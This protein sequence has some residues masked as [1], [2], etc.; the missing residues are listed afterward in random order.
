MRIELNQ[1][2]TSRTA[3]IISKTLPSIDFNLEAPTYRS[4]TK[5]IFKPSIH[6]QISIIVLKKC[7]YL[8][9]YLWRLISDSWARGAFLA[10]W[11]RGITVLA[12]KKDSNVDPSNF[13][14]CYLFCQKSFYLYTS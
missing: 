14:L 9:T 3:T 2:L 12:Y 7:P 4:I 11:K 1:T 10:V 5:I 13:R 6:C 8:R